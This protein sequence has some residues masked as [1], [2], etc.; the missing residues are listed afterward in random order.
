MFVRTIAFAYFFSDNAV[1]MLRKRPQ[2]I[3]DKYTNGEESRKEDSFS[4]LHT[5]NIAPVHQED[6][7]K[8]RI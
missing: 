4:K 1:S 2:C 8:P 6:V 7:M 5:G 3:V